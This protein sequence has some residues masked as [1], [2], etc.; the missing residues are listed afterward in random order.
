MMDLLIFLCGQYHLNPSSHTLDLISTEGSQIKFKPNTPIGMLEVGKVVLKSKIIDDKNKRSHPAAPEQTVRVVINYK[1]TQKTVMRVSPHIPLQDF[2]LSVCNKCEFDPIHTVLLKEH[3]CQQP[4]DL[5]KSLNDLGLR[6]LYAVDRSKAT[7]P[8]ELRSTPLQESCQNLETKSNEDKGF[9][10][11][12]R[13][14]KKKRDQISSAPSTPQLGK[15]RPNP[16][17]GKA[18]PGTVSKPYDTSTITSD[19]PKKRRAPLPPMLPPLSSSNSISR[20]Q[21]RT[22]SCIVKS[23]VPQTEKVAGGIDRSRAGSLQLSGS[24]SFNSPLRTTKRKAP[25]PP[26]APKSSPDSNETA[27]MP[28]DPVYEKGTTEEE[29]QNTAPQIA[30][31]PEPCLDEIKEKE[32]M[33]LSQ[34]EGKEEDK[35]EDVSMSSASTD[36]VLEFAEEPCNWDSD[37]ANCSKHSEDEIMIPNDK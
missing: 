37:M 10:N 4:L 7:S 36:I 34:E 33:F 35:T 22:S 21:A 13:R 16:D 19:V 3:Q 8:T 6:E 2:F 5:T 15:A 9:F 27:L 14:S 30:D 1:K 26:P 17:L 18:R 24:S 31:D 20:G 25:P 23:T 28:E 32:E 11:F 12:F 29:M